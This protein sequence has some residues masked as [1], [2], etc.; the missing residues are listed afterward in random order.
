M[1]KNAAKSSGLP[2]MVQVRAIHP[3]QKLVRAYEAGFVLKLQRVSAL[4]HR[5]PLQEI[6]DRCSYMV[7]QHQQ[8]EQTS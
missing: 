5:M 2:P 6:L 1:A 8:F 4:R 3:A 7:P